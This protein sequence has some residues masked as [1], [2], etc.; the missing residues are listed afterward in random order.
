MLLYKYIKFLITE[1]YKIFPLD[2]Y[3]LQVNTTHV[4][5]R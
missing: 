2:L 5:I 3:I 4:S 1:V